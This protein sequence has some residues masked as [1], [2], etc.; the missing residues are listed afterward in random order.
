MGTDFGWQNCIV[1]G[2]WLWVTELHCTCGQTLGDNCTVHGEDWLW[3]TER[4]RIWRISLTDNFTLCGNH[5]EWQSFVLC[6]NHPDFAVYVDL[7]GMIGTWCIWDCTGNRFYWEY[8][9][10]DVKSLRLLNVWSIWRMTD[11]IRWM[12]KNKID[13]GYSWEFSDYMSLKYLNFDC[14]VMSTAFRVMV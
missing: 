5:F 7:L 2:D 11:S 12:W 1:H 4:H 3:V 8:S 9:G 13:W 14:S 10:V 6:G